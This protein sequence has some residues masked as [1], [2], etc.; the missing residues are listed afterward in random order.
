[1]S[2][3]GGSSRVLMVFG[4]LNAGLL[5]V[6]FV[7]GKRR[8]VLLKSWLQLTCTMAL[9]W[10]E[11]CMFLCCVLENCSPGFITKP[12]PAVL[13]QGALTS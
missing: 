2:H 6:L 7:S 3:R 5:A 10:R 9:S 11:A 12:L 4:W 1:M 13:A 8:R